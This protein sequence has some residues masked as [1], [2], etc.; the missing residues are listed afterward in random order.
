M[1]KKKY[2]IRASEVIEYVAEYTQSDVI[3][4]LREAK[5]MF[6]RQVSEMTWYKHGKIDAKYN[7]FQWDICEEVEDDEER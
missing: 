6:S 4:S 1:K 2:A 5:H 3:P 7:G